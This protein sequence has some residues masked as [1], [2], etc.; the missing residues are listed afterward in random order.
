MGVSCVELRKVRLV[1]QWLSSV[2]DIHLVMTKDR[3][4][5]SSCLIPSSYNHSTVVWATA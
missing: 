1:P 4:D 2:G 5:V 3:V